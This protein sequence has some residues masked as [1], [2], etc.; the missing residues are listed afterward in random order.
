M[1]SISILNTSSLQP[2][3]ISKIS[4]NLIFKMAALADKDTFVIS[5]VVTFLDS[6][7]QCKWCERL[8]AIS[9]E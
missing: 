4:Q 1:D 3:E 2:I 7:E 8:P 5:S 9:H 6:M